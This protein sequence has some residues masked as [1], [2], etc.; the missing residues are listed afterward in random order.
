MNRG[1]HSRQKSH[2]Q[3]VQCTRPS[4]CLRQQWRHNP[5]QL[6]DVTI[7]TQRTLLR[8]HVNTTEIVLKS[9]DRRSNMFLFLNVQGLIRGCSI[10]FI[11]RVIRWICF[12][13]MWRISLTRILQNNDLIKNGGGDHK[14]QLSRVHYICT[15]HCVQ[16]TLEKQCTAHHVIMIVLVHNKQTFKA[17]C[18]RHSVPTDPVVWERIPRYSQC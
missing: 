16:C 7:A 3:S 1:G 8:A 11:S 15:M 10:V 18:N 9:T 5:I 4:H 17:L 6:C 12:S 2:S 14:R 13:K